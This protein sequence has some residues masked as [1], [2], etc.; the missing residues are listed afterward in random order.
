VPADPRLSSA[1]SFEERVAQR[2][3]TIER[4][5][6]GFTSW[7]GNGTAIPSFPVYDTPPA[8]GRVGRV[9][10]LRSTGKLYVD[11]GVVW[12]PQT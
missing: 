4:Q 12:Q 1:G 9:F 3:A 10:V 7:L 6:R 2:L 8:A 5:L 11:D